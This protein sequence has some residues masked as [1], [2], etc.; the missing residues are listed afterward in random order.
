MMYFEIFCLT[1]LV[2]LNT[3]YFLLTYNKVCK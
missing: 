3:L 1:Y 2:V